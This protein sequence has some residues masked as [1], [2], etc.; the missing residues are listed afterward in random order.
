MTAD[1]EGVHVPGP[2]APESR[3]YQ[4][5]VDCPHP[6][7]WTSTDDDSTE[8]EVSDLAWGLVRATQPSLCVE[9][10][11]AW[12]QTAER[13]G[14]A[15]AANGHGHLYTLE[16]DRRRAAAVAPPMPHSRGDGP[17]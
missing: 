15:L 16:P 7:R 8:I 14:W 11:A 3:Y 1:I 12:G 2:P 9:T 17:R 13:I 5:T 10:G 6:E 4:P